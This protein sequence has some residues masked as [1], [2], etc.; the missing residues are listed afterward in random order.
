MS[1]GQG[2]HL[3][4]GESAVVNKLHVM[5][6][7]GLRA[8]QSKVRADVL[9]AL[10]PTPSIGPS[11]GILLAEVPVTLGSLFVQEGTTPGAIRRDCGQ[12]TDSHL[13]KGGFSAYMSLSSF[14]WSLDLLSQD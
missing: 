4:S 14:P 9:E 3:K 1:A 11:A 7:R 10:A 6:C 5:S 8:R 13:V 12:I 2:Y